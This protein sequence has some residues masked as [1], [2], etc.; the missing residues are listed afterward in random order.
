MKI[1]ILSGNPKKEGLCQS[2]IEAA[3]AGAAEAGA[4][5]DEIRLADL[6]L[7]RCQVCAD[8]WGPCRDENY[9]RYGSDGFDDVRA[10]LAECDAIVMATPVYWGE[11]T[12]VLKSFLDR[13]RRCE[14]N[15]EKVL[16]GKQVLLIAS[17]G[18]SGNGLLTCLEQMERF[19][20]HTGAVIFDYLGINRWNSDYKKAAVQAAVAAMAGGRKRGDTV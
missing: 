7:I 3:K 8:G 10:R 1:C 15:Q 12:E 14:F 11:T 16:R 6:K 17:P 18:G 19:C 4:E 13:L 5:V 20:L 2:V 9:C